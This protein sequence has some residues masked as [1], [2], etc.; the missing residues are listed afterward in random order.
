MAEAGFEIEG[1][2]Y[3]VPR[4]ETFDLDEEQIL[5]DVAGVVQLDFVPAHPDASEEEKEF[6]QR[7]MMAR[8]RDPR[9]KRALAHVA[10]R[11]RYPEAAF[12]DVAIRI[13][14]MNALDAELAIFGETDADPPAKSSPSEPESKTSSSEPSN[15]EASGNPSGSD[16][17]PVV[18]LHAATG[19]GR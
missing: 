1:E 5:Y 8:I 2:V 6:V 15:G 4:L 14:K 11:R 9:F 7:A 10:Y 19:A 3:E 18:E 13:G 17:A 12:D 16:S